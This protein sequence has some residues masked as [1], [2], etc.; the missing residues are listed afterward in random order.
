MR[1]PVRHL[2]P[3]DRG[4]DLTRALAPVARG[5]AT[6]LVLWLMLVLVL[7]GVPPIALAVTS[8]VLVG[9][10]RLREPAATALAT[11][12]R[13]R[14][15]L[16][17]SGRQ[18]GRSRLAGVARAGRARHRHRAPRAACGGCAVRTR[19][20]AKVSRSAAPVC[21]SSPQGETDASDRY[22]VQRPQARDRR[23][24][25]PAV[26]PAA[27]P[28]ATERP[29]GYG[30]ANYER[31]FR[32]RAR[33]RRSP[34]G[35]RAGRL[36]EA[37]RAGRHRAG[38]AL[39]RVQRRGGGAARRL[40]AP[41]PRPGPHQRAARHARGAGAGAPRARAEVRR[42]RRLGAGGRHS[43]Q[44]PALLPALRQG[45]RAGHSRAHLLVDELR[46]RSAVRPRPS[47]APRPGGHRF[48]GA[49]AHRRARAAG[50]G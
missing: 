42:A 30:M 8:L 44:R 17:E 9:L 46:D 48:P 43:G 13:A 15:A 19:A 37:A 29:A 14:G 12:Q 25:T 38:R 3:D 5:A 2:P 11:D 50:R 35:H 39:R 32:S 6:A 28:E 23:A 45:V 41:L 27:A 24:K 16:G 33:G 49:D 34:A 21:S 1:S 26:S 4:L 31:I 20:R 7:E 18:A 10:G 47:A 22:G 36:R 40:P